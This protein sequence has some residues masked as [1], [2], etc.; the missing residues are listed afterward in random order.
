MKTLLIKIVIGLLVCLCCPMS[1]A[2][3]YSTTLVNSYSPQTIL[4]AINHYRRQQGLSP[5]ELNF[6]ISEEA[7]IHSMD[8]AEKK[9]PFGHDGF[10]GRVKRLA[11]QFPHSYGIA[12]NVAYTYSDDHDVVKLWLN[13]PGHRKNIEGNYNLTGIG[14]AHDKTGKIYVTQIFLRQ[15][16][17]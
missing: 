3:Q 2:A 7:K 15:D 12:E 8:M 10:Y 17:K 1:S 11:R 4:M 16:K 13:S 14:I 5:L 6:I 9:V